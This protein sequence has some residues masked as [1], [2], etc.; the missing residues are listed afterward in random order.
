MRKSFKRLCAK[1][2]FTNTSADLMRLVSARNQFQ[3][4][5]KYLVAT[6]LNRSIQNANCVCTVLIFAINF[7]RSARCSTVGHPVIG[8]ARL[9]KCACRYAT[10]AVS[11]R[12]DLSICEAFSAVH[13]SGNNCRQGIPRASATNTVRVAGAG[14][15]G[16]ARL[17]LYER[18]MAI[19]HATAGDEAGLESSDM[20][21]ES[22]LCLH[23]NEV[24]SD[25]PIFVAVLQ[26]ERCSGS[27]PAYCTIFCLLCIQ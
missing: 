15:S 17:P 4:C 2:S 14:F 24:L 12:L 20:N 1:H 25:M 26:I 23:A 27:V 22:I 9:S 19:W 5:C 8:T 6:P 3:Y 21:D 10:V 16:I 18:G 11:D 7:F 13:L